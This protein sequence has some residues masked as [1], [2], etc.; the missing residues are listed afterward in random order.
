MKI[1][2]CHT[3]Y[4]Q[5]GGEDE[6]FEDEAYLLESHGHEVVYYTRHNDET[7]QLSR[8]VLGAKTVYN[9]EV[10]RSLGEL[11]RRER[12]D[13]LHCTNAFPLLSPA[14]YDVA[15]QEG[16]PV[17]QALHNYRLL[18]P[19]AVLMRD[20]K[21]CGD[22]LDRSIPW[23]AILHGCYRDSRL[24]TAGIAA[25][26]CYDRWHKSREAAISMY[27]T[28]SEFARRKFIESGLP[29]ERITSKPNFV[30]T[31]PQPGSGR[32]GYAVFV[33]RLAPEKG[34][35]TLLAAWSRLERPISLK[36]IGSGP[37][38]GRVR[39]AAADDR[40]IEVLGVKPLHEVLSIVGDA[41]CLVMPSIWYETFGRTIV[42]A[43][44]RG[45]P[46]ITSRLGAMAELV[47]D[48]HTGF[49][50]EPGNADELKDKVEQLFHDGKALTAMRR[51]ARREYE[52]K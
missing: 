14:M 30:R 5:R 7:T 20:G 32:G 29:A 40:R 16:V 3:Y 36:I 13:L 4:R 6:V 43:F 31:A 46:V 41:A 37:L 34:L 47:T 17:V 33:G 52:D 45:T 2:L 12:P 10:Y 8:L 15:R 11:L 48:G 18:C 26:L 1:L 22:C 44:A 24:A 51:A 39:Q 21:V 49:L 25:M 23:P 19:S 35:D 9:R 27:Y 50:F 28:P 38:E 42:E